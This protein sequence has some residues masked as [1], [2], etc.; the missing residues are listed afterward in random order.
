M[1]FHH[2][3]IACS[4]I[5]ETLD[6][7]RKT[8]DLAHVSDI[9]YDPKQ[10]ASLCMIETSDGLNIE[11]ISGTPVKNMVKKGI[12]LY[13]SCYSVKNIDTAI[14]QQ[15]SL[16]ALL[17]SAPKPAVLLNEERVAFL[18]TPLGLIELVEQP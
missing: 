12:Q 14:E 2:F 16:G 4:D 3:G 7:L 11:L 15:T 18:Q 17:I 8:M 10:D 6:Y 13:H 5:E 1:K 9:T